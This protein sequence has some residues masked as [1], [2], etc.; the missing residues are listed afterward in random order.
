[1][2]T[3]EV[4]LELQAAQE[5]L[6]RAQQRKADAE[7][8]AR[9]A[10]QAALAKNLAD[11]QERL[12]R[13][14]REAEENQKRWAEKRAAEETAKRME[15]A[16]KVAETRRLEAECEA[17]EQ[18]AREEAARQERIRKVQEAARQAEIDAANIEASL[19]QA[20]TPREE[21]KPVTLSDAAHPLSMIFAPDAVPT[22][23][24][25]EISSEENAKLTAQCEATPKSETWRVVKHGPGNNFVNSSTSY[26]LEKEIKKQVGIQANTQ[27]LDLLSSHYD[28]ADLMRAL[29]LAVAAFRERP[30]SHDG[31]LGFL[32]S[33]LV[34]A[35][36]VTP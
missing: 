14:H 8:A 7:N 6:R 17:R 33:L 31:F 30:L 35:A 15:E 23:P 13:L 25:R 12:A 18:A 5:A 2:E 36:N 1:M 27:R 28:E 20:N 3:N 34:E 16:A 9:L 32:E 21:Q 22:A 19:H 24:I 26:L 4:D 11:E 29:G 10:A